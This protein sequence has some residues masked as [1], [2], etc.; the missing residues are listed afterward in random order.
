MTMMRLSDGRT[1][2]WQE[3]GA[4]DAARVLFLHGTPGGRLSAAK[5]QP[6]ADEQGL[7]LVAPERPGYGRSTPRPGMTPTEYAQDLREFCRRRG[8]G[9]VPV[10]AGS[11]GAAYALEF[12]RAC[13]DAVSGLSIFSGIAPMTEREAAGLIPVNQEIRRA[14]REPVALRALVEGVRTA[15]QSGT[16]T[17]V[18]SDPALWSALEPGAE[19]MAADYANVFGDWGFRCEDVDVPVFW[20]H[21]S[22]DV[23]APVQAAR[24][25][26]ARLPHA[27]FHEVPGGGHAPSRQTLRRVFGAAAGLVT[28]GSRRRAPWSPAGSGPRQSAYGPTG[29]TS[30]PASPGHR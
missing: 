20:V 9:P 7:R 6:A 26:A 4:R 3:Y 22:S 10:V 13:P 24:R 11:A 30:T 15:I 2:A 25:L 18:P 17:G 8:W 1:L 12:A 16:L 27:R 21:G 28:T 29:P 14:A 5:Y 19:G 23:N